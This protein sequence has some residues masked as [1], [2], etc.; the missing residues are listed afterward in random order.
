MRRCIVSEK[1]W[2]AIIE[3]VVVGTDRGMT[4][5]F[6]NGRELTV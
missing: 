6:I 5:L 3:K 4:F 1:R 2:N